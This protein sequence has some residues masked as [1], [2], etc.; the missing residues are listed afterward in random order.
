MKKGTLVTGTILL[1]AAWNAAAAD[2]NMSGNFRNQ[3]ISYD[4]YRANEL[5]LDAFGTDT[6]GQHTINHPSTDRIRHNSVLGAGLGVNYFV[7]RYMGVGGDAYTENTAHNFVDNASGNLIFRFPIGETGLAPY[8]YG[9]GG[10]KFDPVSTVFGQA[11]GGLEFRFTHNLGVF[12]DARYV[13][14]DRIRDYGVGRAG[15]RWAF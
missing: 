5:S 14:A 12:V 2:D 7:T 6:L 11:G 8:A 3:N 4:M 1:M 10:Y 13:F 9:G 15:L